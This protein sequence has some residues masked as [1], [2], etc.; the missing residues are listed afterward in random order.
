MN[1]FYNICM[2]IGP[3]N[4]GKSYFYNQV[5]KPQFAALSATMKEPLRVVYLSSD[6]IRRQILGFDAH[7]MSDEM[8]Q[9]SADAFNLLIQRL[10]ISTS[11]PHNAHVVIIDSTGLSEDFRNQVS[12]I[13]AEKNY[14]LDAVVFDYKENE[15]YLAHIPEDEYGYKQKKVTM[16]HLKRLRQDVLKSL[17]R[18]FRQVI[19]FKNKE[20]VS[21]FKVELPVSDYNR[22]ILDEKTYTVIGDIHGCIEELKALLV[23]L[24]VI[25]DGDTIKEVPEKVGSLVLIG[26]LIDKGPSSGEV[27]EFVHKNKLFF[28]L[29]QGNH[30]HWVVNEFKSSTNL[31]EAT[32]RE[33]FS[34]FYE[35]NESQ[36]QK[37]N[38]LYEGSFNFLK[39]KNFILTHAPCEV[40]YLGKL[41]S[42]SQKLM[43]KTAYMKMDKDFET[44]EEAL[45][46]AARKFEYLQTEKNKNHP[47]HIF[48]HKVFPKAMKW[49]NKIAIDS[50]CVYGGF[51]T[52]ITISPKGGI[53][54]TS[55]KT[56]ERVNF[57]PDGIVA[58]F[59]EVVK[60]KTYDLSDFDK[61]RVN[62]LAAEKIQ[63]ISGTIS[64]ADKD[65]SVNEL[66]SLSQGLKY[67]AQKGVKKVILQT[68]HMGSRCNIYLSQ[69]LNECRAVSR[70]GFLIKKV[71]LTTVY[72]SLQ[73]KFKSYMQEHDLKTMILDGE[74]MP[75][76]ALG[77]GLI[78]EQYEVV[79][80]AVKSE[81]SALEKSGFMSAFNLVSSH[82]KLEE[83]KGEVN[84]VSKAKLIE[85][86]GYQLYH[87]LVS[88]KDVQVDL[89]SE[90]HHVSEYSKQVELYGKESEVHFLP[91]MVLKTIT[92]SGVE[93]VLV[94]PT[95]S[96]EENY[97]LVSD[98]KYVMID[99]TLPESEYL[100][101][102]QGFYDESVA[103]GEE[104]IVIKPEFTFMEHMA[105]FIKVRNKE[106]LRIIY[107]YNYLNSE[108][109]A[110]L[111]K[112]KKI[113]KKLRVSQN[114]YGIAK[115]MLEI[116]ES[117]I[118]ADNPLYVAL[119]SQMIAEEMEEQKID[120]RL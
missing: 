103:S 35:L 37:L 83:F 105:P 113:G 69:N 11:Y 59:C 101:F 107:G 93:K 17:K 28:T 67:Y 33:Y 100:P 51:L 42:K 27:I 112:S 71:D 88:L 111:V 72:T 94:S 75:W 108:I 9:A 36:K 106:Y 45:A 49:E 116:P 60:A 50:G 43:R 61:E 44:T 19:K 77:K 34:S 109:Y 115:K 18:E 4:C 65:E 114:E 22:H 24:Q 63:F 117:E 82:P 62:K 16:D 53:Q 68:K 84:K 98:R 70:N 13:A 1:T 30:E 87:T 46:Y 55:I 31:D 97:R 48:G 21:S 74:L 104:G 73:E 14:S 5:L 118:S 29:V 23:K 80:D 64:P 25:F 99:L 91:F 57:G 39:S 32:K 47:L 78:S 6:E 15:D 52:A 90:S 66:E 120:Y 96:T 79:A 81:I 12:A 56:P 89:A 10:T 26:D 86:Y 38:E 85:K 92:N 41:D 102:A 8:Y 110:D 20:E 95:E 40:K 119:I 58:P 7:K 54:F 2:L 76:S 3:S